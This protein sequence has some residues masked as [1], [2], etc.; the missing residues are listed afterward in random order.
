MG[1][2]GT[3]S[4]W[5][6][7]KVMSS[8]CAATNAKSWADSLESSRFRARTGVTSFTNVAPASIV[9]AGN[10]FA[11]ENM[12]PGLYSP[13]AELSRPRTKAHCFFSTETYWIGAIF[14][15]PHLYSPY[16]DHIKSVY[17]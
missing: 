12:R 10:P 13:R 5:R 8:R 16:K 15:A 6:S 17:G 2:L 9:M 7:F 3:S 1:L 11:G 4:T 14:G